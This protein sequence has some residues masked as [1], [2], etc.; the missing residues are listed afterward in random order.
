MAKNKASKEDRHNCLRCSA[1]NRSRGERKEVIMNL[2]QNRSALRATR[3]FKNYT[4]NGLRNT[5][6]L[7]V[8]ISLLYLSQ[9]KV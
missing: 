3:G 7:A 4:M 2:N 1:V 8:S 5:T 6:E 9:T